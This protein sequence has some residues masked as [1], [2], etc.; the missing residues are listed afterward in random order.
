METGLG[1]YG[2][3]GVNLVMKITDNHQFK[4]GAAKVDIT[5]SLGTYINGD[6]VAH[7]AQYI[8][9]PL[10][11]KALVIES[12]NTRIAIIVVDICVMTKSFLDKVK[13]EIER[14]T[15]IAY[16]NILISSTH[17][18]AA[19]SVADVY[20]TP[21]DELYVNKL[22]SLIVRA[23]LN[24]K[25]HL[26]PAKAGFGGIDVPEHVRCRRYYMKG[27]YKA[28]NPVKGSFDQVKTN[29][30]D[31][32][33]LIE[34]PVSVPDPELSYLAIKDLQDN[35]ISLLANYSLHYVGDWESGTISAD[36]FGEFSN[37]IH[38]KLK[39]G[40]DFV[41]MMSNGTSGDVNIWEYR[42]S[43]RYP[44]ENFKKSEFIGNDLADKVI[45]TLESVSWDSS[46]LVQS[47]Y[48]EMIC[49]VVKPG[50]TELNNAKLKVSAA[51]Y[52]NL[53]V[54]QVS[55][56][57]LV[58]LYAREQ[59][60]LHELPD[61]QIFSLQAIRIGG[62]VIG[63]MSG[64]IFAETGLWLKQQSPAKNYFT[65]GLA[66][67]NCGYIPPEH[68]FERGG[69]ETWRSRICNLE[70]DIE[71]KIKIRQLELIKSLIN[72]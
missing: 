53:E 43:E 34:S 26:R 29:P 35:W 25:Q 55:N 13:S 4:A 50:S 18:H 52:E 37:S 59:I 38:Q 33:H 14:N 57:A 56:E 1:L 51:N 28:F 62:G 70:E 48:V 71:E 19:G 7:F 21:A 39:A 65:I 44:K 61:Q 5:P 9:D 23:V 46:P 30:F 27:E 67:G 64:E 17:T 40:S 69:Y 36:Y 60:L 10:F 20:L 47:E 58:S 66:N 2:K 68:E 12:G 31:S 3:P 49:K 24:A 22:P 6:F 41:A 45:E 32:W 54:T 11:A 72:Q 63:G 15:E 42:E 16:E 8:H